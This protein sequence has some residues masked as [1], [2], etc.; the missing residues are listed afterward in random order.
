MKL[1]NPMDIWSAAVNLYP[2]IW[3]GFLGYLL[4]SDIN[5]ENSLES[6]S[7]PV[8]MNFKSIK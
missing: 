1:L 4:E 2:L 8:Y 5:P 7:I 3:A 6:S